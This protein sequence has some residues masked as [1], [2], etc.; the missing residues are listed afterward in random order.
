MKYLKVSILWLIPGFGLEVLNA[1]PV[2]ATEAVVA[3]A[4]EKLK[5]DP[6]AGALSYDVFFGTSRTQVAG[7]Q[8]PPGVN[9]STWLGSTA[10]NEIGAPQVYGPGGVWFWRVDAVTAGTTIK[11]TVNHYSG[12]LALAGNLRGPNS[13]YWLDTQ[14][15]AIDGDAAMVGY[16]DWVS[17]SSTPR[18]GQV[19]VF[20][21]VAG[22]QQWAASQT[23]NKPSGSAADARFGTAILIRGRT[24]WISAPGDE[25]VFR[26]QLDQVSGQW[27]YSGVRLQPPETLSHGKFGTALAAGNGWLAVG[28]PET[29]SVFDDLR[30]KVDIFDP[31]TG[32]WQ[33]RLNAP[34]NSATERVFGGLMSGDGDTLT[35]RQGAQETQ[36]VRVEIFTRAANGTW[37]ATASISPPNTSSNLIFAQSLSL[38]GTV[39]LIGTPTRSSATAGRTY[40]FECLGSA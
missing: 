30:G 40:V 35:V 5:W 24:A 15:A 19:A 33:A 38:S 11:G 3:A 27:S 21:R 6:V 37:A 1:A 7:A 14:T 8:K 36:N 32:A 23:L 22:Q 25:S 12:Q 4:P 34:P 29:G 20:R 10:I 17:A 2:P 39:L 9:S 26:Y 31:A 16:P 28:V 13:Y 18:P